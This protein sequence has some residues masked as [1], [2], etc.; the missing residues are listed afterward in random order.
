M[1]FQGIRQGTRQATTCAL[2][3]VIK[4]QNIVLFFKIKNLQITSIICDPKIFLRYYSV[5]P[6]IYL[7]IYLITMFQALQIKQH[8]RA[9]LVLWQLIQL[10]EKNKLPQ[11]LKVVQ[12]VQIVEI[13]VGSCIK[14]GGSEKASL[15]KDI[16]KLCQINTKT[17]Y[18]GYFYV[19]GI[20]GVDRTVKNK[21]IV[22][23]EGKNLA[24]IVKSQVQYN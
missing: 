6:S 17:K 2:E 23:Y 12:R 9:A 20:G 24:D 7:G 21:C 19:Q 14:V 22:K 8:S 11:Q 4:L 5:N 3:M 18:E 13:Y 1:T 10:M 15:R 16:L